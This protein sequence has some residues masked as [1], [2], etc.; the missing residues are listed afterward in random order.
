[1]EI[2]GRMEFLGV[3]CWSFVEIATVTCCHGKVT[4]ENPEGL[5][6]REKDS[7]EKPC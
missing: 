4:F 3:T 7:E 1:M 2:Y 5:N 6:N